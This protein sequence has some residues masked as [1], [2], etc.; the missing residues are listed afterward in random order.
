MK[1]I[2]DTRER[3]PLIFDNIEIVWKK[4]DVG[5]YSIE[6]YENEIIFER[7]SIPDLY[8]SLV[9]ERERFLRCVDRMKDIRL[10]YLIVEG[11]L[12]SI[13]R[14]IGTQSKANPNSIIGS[15]LSLNLKHNIQV[16]FCS[17]PVFTKKY[18]LALCEK[19]IKYKGEGK[20]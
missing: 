2:I 4:L 17:T 3:K 5:D 19:F 13:Y 8:N 16:L 1:I 10:K 18:L 9:H 12:S 14:G 6:G 15:M 7:K 20:C 11:N